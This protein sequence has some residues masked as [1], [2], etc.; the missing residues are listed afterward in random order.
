MQWELTK[1]LDPT[2]DLLIIGLCD[3]CAGRIRTKNQENS[4]KEREVTFQIV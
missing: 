2:D 1:I 4:W 3:R